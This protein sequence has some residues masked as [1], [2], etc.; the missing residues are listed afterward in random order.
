MPSLTGASALSC[1][2]LQ[3]QVPDFS[4]GR[5]SSVRP[6]GV[7]AAT[8]A[9]RQHGL[10]MMTEVNHSLAIPR[11]DH[12]PWAQLGSV[13]DC[14]FPGVILGRRLLEMWFCPPTLFLFSCSSEVPPSSTISSIFPSLHTEIIRWVILFL[15]LAPKLASSSH[16]KKPKVCLIST[17]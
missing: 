17:V 8:P 15:C 5:G 16:I 2:Y 9:K 7:R 6:E 10:G 13:G 4:A 3:C 1:N 14:E 11:H 12:K